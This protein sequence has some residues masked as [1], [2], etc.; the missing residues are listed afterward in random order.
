MLWSGRQSL[1]VEENGQQI[2]RVTLAEL[3]RR[4]A[5]PQ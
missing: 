5:R 4:A 3:S 1:P 2:G